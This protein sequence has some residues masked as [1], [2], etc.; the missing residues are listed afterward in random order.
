MLRRQCEIQ[1][2]KWNVS[3]L[4]NLSELADVSNESS[5]SERLSF[6]SESSPSERHSRSDKELSLETPASSLIF[7]SSLSFCFR[8]LS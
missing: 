5:L 7:V 2:R 8:L 1:S 4:P 3:E 6:L